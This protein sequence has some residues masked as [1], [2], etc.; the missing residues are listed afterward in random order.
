MNRKDEIVVAATLRAG[1]DQ[2]GA[3]AIEYSL[4]LSVIAFTMIAA[5]SSAGGF[6]SQ[7]FENFRQRMLLA[8]GGSVSSASADGMGFGSD[9]EETPTNPEGEGDDPTPPGCIP[10]GFVPCA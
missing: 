1:M 8:G 2:R 7:L 3:A 6:A 10:H 5:L 4:L 9:G